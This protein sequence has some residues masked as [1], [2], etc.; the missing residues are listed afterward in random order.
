MRTFFLFLFILFCLGCSNQEQ[1]KAT[2]L[3][4]SLDSLSIL[5]VEFDSLLQEVQVLP[6]KYRTEILLNISYRHEVEVEKVQKQVELLHD[7]LSFSSKSEKEKIIYQSA[8]LYQAL[9]KLRVPNA[10]FEGLKWCTLLEENNSLSQEDIWKLENLKISFFNKLE[11]YKESIPILYKLLNEHRDAKDVKAII[12]DYCAIANLFVRLGDLEKALEVYNTA[13]Q[14]A[15][16]NNLSEQ[17]T[18][19][20]GTIACLFFD[21]K[22]Y[23]KVI[24][25]CNVINADTMALSMPS[26]YSMLS[27]CYL[28][29]QKTDS[30]RLCLLEMNKKAQRRDGAVFN[31]QMA[32]TY[33]AENQEDSAELYLNRAKMKFEKRKKQND[34]IALPMYFM[35]AFAS[36]GS[37]LVRNGKLKQA[38]EVFH[39]IEP[40]MK[41]SITNST[42]QEKQI[43]ALYRYNSYCRSTNQY[44]K[45]ADLLVYRDSI[46]KVYN[47]EKAARD[48]KNWVYRYEIQEL[49]NKSEVQKATLNST[50]I[51][52]GFV[53]ALLAIL[54]LI[55][56]VLICMYCKKSKRVSEL[57]AELENYRHPSLLSPKQSEPGPIDLQEKLYNY[58]VKIVVTKKLFLDKKITLDGLA[59]K[60]KTN[61]STLSACINR[62]SQCNFNQWINNF[63]ID[64]IKERIASSDDIR[65][66]SKEAGFNAYNTFCNCFKEHTG[67][68]PYEYQK[69]YKY[70]IS[71][72]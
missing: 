13:Y 42:W 19:C 8:V 39:Y 45:A 58:V 44:K 21:L 11:E 36:Y 54:I 55:I 1:E 68:T 72:N 53:L 65:A 14:I 4:H 2:H 32:E 50:I 34:N 35:P 26:I 40:L 16:K 61:R 15:V 41:D 3:N 17:Q 30:A 31:Y 63:R 9:D 18:F 71:Q 23:R 48:S 38:G 6:A 67:K 20:R 29:L 69:I 37:L 56:V 64:Y 12:E 60:V 33:I 70:D 47:D 5:S 24:Q 28:Q 43:E 52:T 57:N 22:R 46:L 51:V 62:Y 25:F 66:L 7:A 10:A 59:K 49:T 27:T